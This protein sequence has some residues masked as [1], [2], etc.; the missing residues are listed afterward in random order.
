MNLIRKFKRVI[1]CNLLYHEGFH[2]TED[3][4]D[5]W[6]CENCRKTFSENFIEHKYNGILKY[7]LEKTN[8][9]VS[10]PKKLTPEDLQLI[11]ICFPTLEVYSK[12]WKI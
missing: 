8:G 1:N 7:Y 2:F 5:A 12:L 10:N 3:N 9:M 4:F 11:K 6:V